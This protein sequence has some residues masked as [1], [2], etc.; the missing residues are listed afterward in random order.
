MTWYKI[1]K[2]QINR[3]MGLM[4]SARCLS[5]LEPKVFIFNNK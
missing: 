2:H 5:I 4:G 3:A 1:D